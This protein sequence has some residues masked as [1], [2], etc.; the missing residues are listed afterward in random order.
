MHEHLA[1]T[2]NPTTDTAAIEAAAGRL[3]LDP[4]QDDQGTLFLDGVFKIN[5]P[6]ILSSETRRPVLLRGMS[7]ASLV[8]TGR[9]TDEPMIR[10]CGQGRGCATRIQGLCLFCHAKCRGIVFEHQAYVP[11]LRECELYESRQIGIEMV[12]CWCASIDTVVVN[13]AHG[14]GLQCLDGSVSVTHM[15]FN[16]TADDWPATGQ[17]AALVIG[18]HSLLTHMIFEGGSYRE[19]PLI[20]S[21]ACVSTWEHI[22]IE[23]TKS[24]EC[25]I[26]L[27]GDEQDG[28]VISGKGRCCTIRNLHIGMPNTYRCVVRLLGQ[29]SGTIIDGAL[30]E[31]AE[32]IVGTDGGHHSY[33]IRRAEPWRWTT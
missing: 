2:G 25:L 20:A 3:A 9:L 30:Y 32:T 21:H 29:T 12:R 27:S 31:G 24:T 17:R 26:A 7:Q 1:A 16:G 22:R 13:A 14:V 18:G 5:R 6:L 8:W 4:A 19:Y 28:S 11:V 15:R 33:E 10:Y 23:D